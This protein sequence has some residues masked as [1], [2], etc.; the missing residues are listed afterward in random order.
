MRRRRRRRRRGREALG[1]AARPQGCPAGLAGAKETRPRP[2]SPGRE[3]AG[4]RG[5]AGG[6][7]R[8]A[9]GCGGAGAPGWR[10]REAGARAARGW[11]REQAERKPGQ[12]QRGKRQGADEIQEEE[13]VDEDEA[14]PPAGSG[15]G[16]GGGREKRLAGSWEDW[17]VKRK[18]E[19]GWLCRRGAGRAAELT[20]VARPRPQAPAPR[21]GGWLQRGSGREA[22]AFMRI[23]LGGRL[24]L[25]PVYLPPPAP[26]PPP[27]AARPPAAPPCSVDQPADPGKKEWRT[28]EGPG[29]AGG[30]PRGPPLRADEMRGRVGDLKEGEAG[31]SC[32][33]P[34]GLWKGLEEGHGTG[35]PLGDAHGA[36]RPLLRGTRPGEGWK[37]NGW[38]CGQGSLGRPHSR[39]ADPE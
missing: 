33:V 27:A 16:G 23:L 32:P 12:G 7:R 14:G 20:L 18:R 28:N 29:P 19:K 3:A 2:S 26:V 37:R 9:L 30:C 1:G 10:A 24:H 17:A 25:S 31:A 34:W 39:R 5:G 38:V 6:G 11:R 13:E 15:G 21:F 35:P 4:A 36:V 8:E 22:L